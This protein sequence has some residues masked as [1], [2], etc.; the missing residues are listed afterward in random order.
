MICKGERRFGECRSVV[1]VS[2]QVEPVL[3]LQIE[4]L[5][6]VDEQIGKPFGSYFRR[7][8]VRQE[9]SQPSYVALQASGYVIVTA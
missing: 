6:K 1:V 9:L 5:T 7:R 3:N 8:S 2:F 4:I